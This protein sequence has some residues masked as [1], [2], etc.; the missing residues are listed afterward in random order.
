M[1]NFVYY[2][3]TQMLFRAAALLCRTLSVIS[4]LLSPF[5]WH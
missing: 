1:A 5:E 2:G 4:F 3:K